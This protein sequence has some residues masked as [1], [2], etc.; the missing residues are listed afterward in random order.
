MGNWQFGI[1]DIADIA[2]VAIVVYFFLRL[3]RGTRAVQMLIG[4]AI[5]VV[6]YQLAR[7]FG[8]F[9]VEWIFS[10]FFSA[11]IVI[12]VVLFQQEIRRALMRVA[13]NPLSGGSGADATTI[14]MLVESAFSLVHRGWGGL[15]VIERDTG[16]RHLFDS[17]VELDAPVQPDV[18]QSL[19]CPDS[20]MHDGAVV[21]D[22]ARVV[23]ARVLLP[24]AQSNAVPGDFGTRHRAAVGISEETDA[25]V[26]VVS[27]ETG[28]VHLVEEG[29]LGEALTSRM[30]HE[31]LKRRLSSIQ[32][33]AQAAA[34]AGND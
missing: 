18:I 21:V 7:E 11:F 31:R 34:V 13:V 9:T 8:L 12:L 3:I 16:L 14:A 17:G 23:A 28:A 20:P 29:Q 19:F 6:V 32:D 10:H 24:L 33:R 5:V 15:I 22:G 25:L 1:A 30:L 2:V 4:V 27:E 26:I